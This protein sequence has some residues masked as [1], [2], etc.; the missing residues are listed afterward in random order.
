MI[1]DSED[2]LLFIQTSESSYAGHES[3]LNDMVKA[4]LFDLAKSTI[5][6]KQVWKYLYSMEFSGQIEPS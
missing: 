6:P 2:Q 1:Y 4:S 3:K 5:N